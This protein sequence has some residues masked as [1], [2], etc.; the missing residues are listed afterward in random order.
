LQFKV[1][2]MERLLEALDD[3]NRFYR[4]NYTFAFL[5]IDAFSQHIY[6]ADKVCV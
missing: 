3:G 5:F 1:D 6:L 2:G 4:V